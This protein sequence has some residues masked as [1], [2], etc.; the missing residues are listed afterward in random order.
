MSVLRDSKSIDY[1]F[2]FSF[3]IGLKVNL[4]KPPSELPAT[5]IRI[6]DPSQIQNELKI[7]RNASMLNP[8]SPA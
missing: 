7:N 4:I 8:P 6:T 1:S 3:R 2:V 5:P